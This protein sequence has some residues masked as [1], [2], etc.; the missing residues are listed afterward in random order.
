MVTRYKFIF[1]IFFC[2][3]LVAVVIGSCNKI[4]PPQW[5][6]ASGK[7]VICTKW[8]T[9]VAD[10]SQILE[11]VNGI[12]V[13][14]KQP[15]E[16]DDIK[17][18]SSTTSFFASNG[19]I[20]IL[21]HVDQIACHQSGNVQ[22]EYYRFENGDVLLTGVKTADSSRLFIIYDPP[23]MLVPDNLFDM[24]TKIVCQARSRYHNELTGLQSQGPLVHIEIERLQKGKVLYQNKSLDAV[25]CK[26]TLSQDQEINYQDTKFTLPK[27]RV[28]SNHLL[29][30][31]GVGTLLEWGIRYTHDNE[32]TKR[33]KRDNSK[34]DKKLLIVLHKHTSHKKEGENNEI[35]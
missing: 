5:W 33:K 8:F 27:T 21:G 25:V 4:T 3:M 22:Q 13:L 11:T 34:L 12:W 15:L 2:M 26:V 16:D 18:E 31:R 30:A 1:L 10:T 23:I 7:Q 19:K 28:I 6:T 35:Q 29:I 32:N 9:D 17:T 14:P 24:D 20:S